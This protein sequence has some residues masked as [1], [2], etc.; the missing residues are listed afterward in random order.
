MSQSAAVPAQGKEF[1]T[2]HPAD[3]DQ[4]R[5]RDLPTQLEQQQRHESSALPAADI[6]R[7][8]NI[9]QVSIGGGMLGGTAAFMGGEMLW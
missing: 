4:L 5:Q 9:R 6:P 8:A 7:P 3:Q 1:L 2:G